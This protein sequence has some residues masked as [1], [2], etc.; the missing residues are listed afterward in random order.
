MTTNTRRRKSGAYTTRSQKSPFDGDD[1]FQALVRKTARIE[2]LR[3]SGE[4]KNINEINR[5]RESVISGVRNFAIDHNLDP[6]TVAED[7]AKRF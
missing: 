2:K 6:K 7:L 3:R 1:S 4:N 5:L